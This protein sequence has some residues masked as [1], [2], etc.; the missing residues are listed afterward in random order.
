MLLTYLLTVTVPVPTSSSWIKC[1][2]RTLERLEVV[3][4]LEMFLSAFYDDE[5][6][7]EP[8]TFLV[9]VGHI[10]RRPHQRVAMIR[11]QLRFSCTHP[12]MLV[13]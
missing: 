3:N 13:V 9:R 12:A 7:V 8:V 1:I 4:Q 6:S 11:R 2:S 10:H 5:R